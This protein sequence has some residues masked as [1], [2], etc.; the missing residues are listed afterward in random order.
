MFILVNTILFMAIFGYTAM[1]LVKFFKRS[2]QG[3]CGG[4]KTGCD[5]NTI[6]TSNKNQLNI[7]HIKS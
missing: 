4:C 7:P 3:K 2:K 6:P 5:C 1:T